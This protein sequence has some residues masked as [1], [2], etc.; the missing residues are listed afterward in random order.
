MK[1]KT[2]INKASTIIILFCV[3]CS[4]G[5]VQPT[6]KQKTAGAMNGVKIIKAK[7]KFANNSIITS[8][9]FPSCF[10]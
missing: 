4:L 1:S 8:T 2:G 6:K 5:I 9:S 10:K 7:K 3:I